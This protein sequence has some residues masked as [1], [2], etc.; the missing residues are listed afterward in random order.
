MSAVMFAI[1]PRTTSRAFATVLSGCAIVPGFASSPFGATKIVPAAIA[2][3]VPAPPPPVPPR[4]PAALVPALPCGELPP[5][6]AAPM[7][8]PVPAW[9]P[10]PVVIPIVPSDPQPADAPTRPAIA[11]WAHT[12]DKSFILFSFIT[13]AIDRG[14]RVQH[15][16]IIGRSGVRLSANVAA[17]ITQRQCRLWYES[18]FTRPHGF[19]QS[20][21]NVWHPPRSHPPQTEPIPSILAGDVR[22]ACRGMLVGLRR[23]AARNGRRSRVG[24]FGRVGRVGR[25]GRNAGRGRHRRERRRAERHRR[26]GWCRRGRRDRRSG[27]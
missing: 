23:R 14:T 25:I 18:S 2:P 26:T 9:P 12:D 10:V 19:G 15:D 8:P 16:P 3:P 21:T 6:P 27:R 5:V 11:R 7:V 1:I 13:N 24:R 20:T 4:P 22:A 17:D